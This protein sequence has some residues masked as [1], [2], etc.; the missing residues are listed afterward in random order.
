MGWLSD[1]FS[2]G[3]D[4]VVDSVGKALDNLFTS[5][6]ERLRLKNALKSAM[7]EFKLK[8]QELI[9][10]Q[11]QMQSK[12]IRAEAN[13]ESYLQRNWRPLTML[14]FVFIIA[15]TY[16]ISP[17]LSMLFSVKLNPPDLT[18][19]MWELLKLGIGG[20]VIGRSLEKSVKAYKGVV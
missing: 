5:D 10:Q 20:Y 18:P 9:N 3:V 17:Y 11:M 13:G 16:I 8:A 2:S 6:E 4:K 7:D 1:I 14:T 15:N 19:E 12:N